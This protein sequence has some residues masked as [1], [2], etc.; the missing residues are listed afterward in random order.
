MRDYF[1]K[2]YTLTTQGMQTLN[3]SNYRDEQL[4]NLAMESTPYKASSPKKSPPLAAL[5][6]SMRGGDSRR[7][8]FQ[9]T[10]EL[11]LES[12]QEIPVETT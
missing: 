9:L 12:I 1:L 6:V 11:T 4:S 3:L 10:S 5:G 7:S 2:N 8:D